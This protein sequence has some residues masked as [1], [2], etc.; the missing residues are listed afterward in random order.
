MRRFDMIRPIGESG[1]LIASALAGS[2]AGGI[3]LGMML[4][5]EP[6]TRDS[7]AS[8]DRRPLLC[9]PAVERLA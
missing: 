5:M 9:H 6:T 1:H 8:L 2:C 7:F 4:A 3:G